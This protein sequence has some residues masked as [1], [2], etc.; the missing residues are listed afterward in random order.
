MISGM[1]SP[2]YNKIAA[3]TE[4]SAR[5]T[6]WNS[7]LIDNDKGQIVNS[8]S[9]VLHYDDHKRMLDDV[10][11]ARKYVPTAYDA[12]TATPGIVVPVSLSDTIVGYQ[13]MNEFSAETSMNGSNRTSNQTDYVYSWTP[14]PIHHGDFHIP[15]RQEGFGYKSTDGATEM[16]MQVALQRDQTLLL[17]N[18][19]IV[20]N[21]NGVDAELFG[22]TNHPATLQAPGSL[23]DWAD[24]ANTDTISKEAIEMVG[25]MFTQ[26][27][28]AQMPNSVITFVANDVWTNLENDYASAKGDR[29]ILERIKAITAIRD[30]MPSQWLPDGAVL[31]VEAS[32]MTLRI[33]TSTDIIVT[34]WTQVDPFEDRRFTVFAANSLQVRGDR[35]NN[36][37]IIYATKA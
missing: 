36:T 4:K 34:P 22:L 26:K 16:A 11:M 18:S 17:G 19:D 5:A 2:L 1:G 33:P 28:S 8:T 3:M 29:T 9:G 10:V 37:G 15:W 6:V 23:T 32:P 30:V 31:M 7:Q 35:N 21:V 13:N 24:I 14:Q 25:S 20:V 27:I 12:F